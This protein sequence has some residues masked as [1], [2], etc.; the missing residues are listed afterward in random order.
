VAVPAGLGASIAAGAMAASGAGAAGAGLLALF[1]MS[2]LKIGATAVVALALAG[3]IGGE[4][5]A[6]QALRTELRTIGGEDPAPLLKENRRLAAELARRG[7]ENPAVAEIAQLQA[8]AAT[9]RARPDGVLDALLKP[10]SAHRNAGRATP[11]ALHET[12]VWAQFTRDLDTTAS[13]VIFADD[14]A[15]ARTAFMA[16]FSEAVRA[17]Y[18]TPER[19]VAA[20]LF[21]L[22]GQSGGLQPGDAFQFL[23]VDDH[24]GGDGARYGQKTLRGWSR[25]AAG[26]ERGI[27][28]R[29]EPTPVGYALS[30]LHFANAPRRSDDAGELARMMIDPTTGNLRARPAATP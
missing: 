22:D 15:A 11:E 24:V 2:K 10:A 8:R 13:F 16:Q 3:T 17:R 27:G 26:V 7:Q 25:T 23:G 1:T 28:F 20:A 21:G 18:R 19:L 6:R 30:R 14:S 29:I 9:L 5:R 12:L 4:L